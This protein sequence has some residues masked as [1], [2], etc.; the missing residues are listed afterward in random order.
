MPQTE[1]INFSDF[2]ASSIHDMKNSLN[3]Q[4]GFLEHL[5]HSYHD[6]VDPNTLDQLGHT[7][8]EAGRMNVNL[9]QILS[10]Y[11]LGNSIY[12]IDIS[13]RSVTEM[14]EEVVLQNQSIMKHKGIEIIV[15]CAPDHYWYFD[16]DLVGGVLVNALNNAYNY[17]Q[18]KIRIAADIRD[19]QLEIRVEDNG[20]GY[21]ARMLNE[22]VNSNKGVNFSTGSTGLGF[23]FSSRVAAMHKNGERQGVLTIENGG[24]YNGGCF[25]LTLP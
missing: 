14:L 13:E 19:D 3:I 4:V 24:A 22:N 23:Y 15:D 17:T 6:K 16:R 7:I 12:P 1:D 20:K 18:D 25:V 2:I 9:V 21:P 5:M 11:K 10:L 8:Y